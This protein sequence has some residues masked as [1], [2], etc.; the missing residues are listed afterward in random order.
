[1]TVRETSSREQLELALI[2]NLQR[3]D[4]G[5]LEE[6]EAYRRLVD[7]F[8]LTQLQVAERMGRSRATVTNRLRL[9]EL[10]PALLD[11]LAAGRISEGHARALLAID[12]LDERLEVLRRVEREGLSVR[13]TERLV[14]GLRQFGPRRR[15]PAPD[16]ELDELA[17]ALR[18]SL[19]TKVGLRRTKRGSGTLTIQFYSDEQLDGLLERLLPEW[20]PTATR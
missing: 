19:G 18:R 20:S 17:E 10:P 13:Q 11:A 9:L 14:R 16:P 8:G 4:L 1:M 3:E 5:P 6:A 2:E 15:S 12:G 7:E